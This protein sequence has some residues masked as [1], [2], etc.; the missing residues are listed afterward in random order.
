MSA[1][2][3]DQGTAMP[4]SGD[5]NGA[6]PPIGEKPAPVPAWR[7]LTTLGVA[8]ALAGV[9]I[10][11]VFQWAQPR[12]R[13]HRAE[14]LRAAIQ[15]VLEEP[16]HYQRLFVVGGKLTEQA[17]QGA[18]TTELDAIYLGFDANGRAIG[19]AVPAAEPGFQDVISLIFGYD[20]ARDRL[21]G[22][23]VLE[24]KETPGLGDRITSDSGFISG[25][26]GVAPP[27]VGVKVGAGKDPEHDVDMITGATI[28][29]RAVIGIINHRLDRLRPVLRAYVGEAQAHP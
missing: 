10:V 24:S 4:A 26:S 29:S 13:A 17:P 11:L 7:L 27:L 18:D 15:E 6:T 23:T 14:V 3:H 1:H 22:M 21:L 5:P 20:A 2:V 19:F 12:I 25:F 9:L 16:D 28:S 8:G